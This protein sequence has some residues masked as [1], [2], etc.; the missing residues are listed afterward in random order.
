MNTSSPPSSQQ[1]TEVD[2]TPEILKR[3]IEGEFKNVLFMVGAGISTAAGIPDFRT[4]GTGLYSNLEKLDLPYAEA[5]FD[6][7][8]LKKRP[9][10]F[11]T[12]A[13][14]M[15]PDRFE[16]TDFHRFIKWVDS[17]G[18]LRRC[19]TQ[20]IDTLE[21]RAGIDP[22]KIVEAH[23]SFHGNHCIECLEE[24]SSSR[25]E[26]CLAADTIEVPRCA[27]CKGVVKPDIVFFGEGLPERFFDCMEEDFDDSVD[28]VIVAGTSLQVQPFANL[29]DMVHKNCPRVL[30]NMEAVGSLGKRRNDSLVLGDLADISKIMPHI[31]SD[32]AG[33]SSVDRSRP[34]RQDSDDSLSDSKA[35]G[36]SEI[37]PAETDSDRDTEGLS[38]ELAGL[39]V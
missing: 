38:G 22:A 9:E 25:M 36:L 16:P 20:N 17:Q 28:L 11:Y 31:L 26:E 8:Y 5:V 19:Y 4:P 6:I 27:S 23:G 18:Y 21:R 12:L 3:L 13:K 32:A 29:P 7:D 14:D 24:F 37:E 35:A 39:K 33:H 2:V 10:A 34:E 15:N 30:F 1:K